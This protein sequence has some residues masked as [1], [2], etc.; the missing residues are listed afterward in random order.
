[1]ADNNIISPGIE[2]M[3]FLRIA[4]GDE[5]SFRTLFNLV[6]PKLH[7]FILKF[8]RSESATQEIIQETFIRVWLGRDKLEE[9]ENPAAWL[10]K[11]ASNECYAFI[12][13]RTINEKVLKAVTPGPDGVNST[14]EW[15][16]T[17]EL[18]R[19][20][21]EAVDEL[22]AQRKKIYQM[23]RDQHKT[24]PQIAEEL[25]LSPNTVKNAL[26]TSLRSIRDHLAEHG[27]VFSLF[28][29]LFGEP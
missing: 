5:A 11:V 12:R 10:Y 1:M 20:V 9:I 23:S 2:K 15:H 21:K 25:Q 3:L 19:L 17:K 16:D 27:I 4:E 18:K 26:V 6:L 29:L 14:H 7:P 24:I 28:L 13:K 8:T 22:P